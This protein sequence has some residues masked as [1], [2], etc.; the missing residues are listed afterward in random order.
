MSS[1]SNPVTHQRASAIQLALA[2]YLDGRQIERAIGLWQE[3]YASQPTFFLQYYVRECCELLG[4]ESLRTQLVQSL[5]R[6]LN[7]QRLNPRETAATDDSMSGPVAEAS[8]QVF[9]QLFR[10]LI[11]SAGPLR[12]REI[13]AYVASGLPGMALPRPVQRSLASWLDGSMPVIEASVAPKVLTQLINRAYVGLCEYCGPV[14]A[15][16]I[17][18]EAVSQVAGSPAARLFP[19][20]RLL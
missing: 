13:A 4:V 16:R 11:N 18:H 15:D 2:P 6:E 20:Q 8:V 1:V 10:L 19:P 3:K 7:S 14:K 12:G 9:Q 17:L 5:V